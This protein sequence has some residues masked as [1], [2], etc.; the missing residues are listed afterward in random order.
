MKAVFK[1]LSA[2][3]FDR[4]EL[5]PLPPGELDVQINLRCDREA[6]IKML[7]F[8]SGAGFQNMPAE[9]PMVTSSPKKLTSGGAAK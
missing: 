9:P 1:S 3:P 2:L 8:F 4:M 7:A 5:V 6:Y